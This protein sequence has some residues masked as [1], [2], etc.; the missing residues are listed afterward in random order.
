PS[1]NEIVN[2]QNP[3]VPSHKSEPQQFLTIVAPCP[4]VRGGTAA[5][6]RIAS[7]HHNAGFGRSL[8]G[9]RGR[10]SAISNQAIWL[11]VQRC[12]AGSTAS[13]LSRVAML[14]STSLGLS[15]ARQVRGVPQLPQKC[16]SA[17]ADEL[18]ATGS[19]DVT[20]KPVSGAVS[21]A[22]TGALWARWHI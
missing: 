12:R 7:A 9:W 4:A 22:T 11:S 18:Y 19:P 16:R 13:G 2:R 15:V 17:L 8:V 14:T 10:R 5:V 20:A 3:F 6:D 1:T 21:Q